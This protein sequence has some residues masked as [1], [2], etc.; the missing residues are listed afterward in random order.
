MSSYSKNRKFVL[1]FSH[2]CFSREVDFSGACDILSLTVVVDALKAVEEALVLRGCIVGA[3][4]SATTLF[5][6]SE[7]PL[8]LSS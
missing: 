1:V 3:M 8:S 6:S 2:S 4:S 7:K 5:L